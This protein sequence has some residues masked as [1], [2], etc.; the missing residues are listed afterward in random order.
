MPSFSQ[1]QAKWIMLKY[2]KK[3]SPTIVRTEIRMFFQSYSSWSTATSGI[4]THHRQISED[5]Q[6]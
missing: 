1:E 6:C 3:K 4:P 2:A 5:W